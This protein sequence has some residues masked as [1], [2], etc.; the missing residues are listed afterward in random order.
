MNLGRTFRVKERMTFN[1]RMELTNVFNRAFWSDPTASNANAAQTRLA[2]G[3]TSAGFGKI[4]TTTPTAFGSV[5]NLLP[6]QGVVVG[7]FTF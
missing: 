6:R 3:N 7:R 4:L 2:N 5:A 1:I